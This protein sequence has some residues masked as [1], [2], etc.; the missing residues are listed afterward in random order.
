MWIFLP[1]FSL[2]NT[3]YKGP[4]LTNMWRNNQSEHEL[5]ELIETNKPTPDL[6]NRQD[7]KYI[8]AHIIQH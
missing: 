7:V 5:K 6:A 3:K 1:V 2:K 8:L 4:P